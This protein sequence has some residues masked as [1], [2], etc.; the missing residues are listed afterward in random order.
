MFQASTSAGRLRERLDLLQGLMTAGSALQRSVA[1]C[2]RVLDCTSSQGFQGSL[3]FGGWRAFCHLTSEYLLQ[4]QAHLQQKTSK[5]L[6]V[7]TRL[8]VMLGRAALMSFCWPNQHKRMTAP[9]A[10]C[11]YGHYKAHNVRTSK[12]FRLF[13]WRPVTQ[14]LRPVIHH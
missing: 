12:S 3:N 8:F 14:H 6:L 5:S 9:W 10:D 13:P 1:S 7:L 11:N 2:Q 4:K